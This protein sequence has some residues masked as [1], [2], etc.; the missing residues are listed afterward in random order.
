M[1]HYKVFYAVAK[2]GSISKASESLFITQPAVSRSISQLEKKIDC[3]LFHRT[4]KGVHLTDEG[5]ILFEYIEQAIK[6]ITMGELKITEYKNLT[7]GEISIGASDTILKHFIIPILKDFKDSYPGI[8]IRISNNTT[9]IIL[10]KLKKGALDIGVVNF[11]VNDEQITVIKAMDIQDCFVTGEKFRKLSAKRMSVSEIS[12]YPILLLEKESNSRRFID[13]YFT[14]NGISVK[15]EFELSNFEMLAQLAMI[16]FGI[17]C[18][19]KNF[20]TYEL[21]HSLLYEIKLKEAIPH[22]SI[23]IA[24]LKA[25]PLSASS[26]KFLNF[27]LG[28][29]MRKKF[30]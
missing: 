13:E 25:V 17:A 4:S 29:Q 7:D 30:V 12:R 8:R 1:D 23:G 16:D 14:G 9:P 3:T 22:R 5:Q 15:P 6:Y 26:K 2:K 10:E 27:I 20:I 18:V 19:V 24:H 28:D 11:P 21:D